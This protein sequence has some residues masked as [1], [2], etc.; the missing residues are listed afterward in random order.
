MYNVFSVVKLYEIQNMYVKED[1][2]DVLWFTRM[3]EHYL[4]QYRETKV[5]MN[6]INKSTFEIKINV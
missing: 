3:G 5:R 2:N 1:I 4:A 6:Q